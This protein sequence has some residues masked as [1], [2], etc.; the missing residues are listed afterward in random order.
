MAS[1]LSDGDARR[2][3]ERA[4][5]VT[6]LLLGDVRGVVD[7]LRQD[8]DV[9]LPAALRKLGDGI[10]RPRIHIE[11]APELAVEDPAAGEVILRCARRSSR[12]RFATPAPRTCG[13][14]SAGT[15]AM[16]GSRPDDGCGAQAVRSGNRLLGLRERF[17]QR[18][19]A[20]SFD[21]APGRGFRV[22]AV[23]PV[24]ASSPCLPV[25]ASGLP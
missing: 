11:I 24:M 7:A 1:H 2:H 17:E 3:V 9:D 19:G 22:T 6:K 20:F 4:Q 12:T 15:A 25:A 13:S 14:R 18:G 5:S 8:Q 10:P 16:S 21:T 23:L